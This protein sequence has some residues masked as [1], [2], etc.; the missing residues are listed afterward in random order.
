MALDWD[1]AKRAA[2]RVK[3]GIDFASVGQF[4]WDAALVRADMRI[5]YGEVRLVALGRIERV[6][7]VLIFTVERRVVRIIS[8][9]RANRKEVRSYAEQQAAEESSDEPPLAD[10]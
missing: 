10:R 7:H 5:S 4:E 6:L 1:E 2:N 9:R 8:L 3:H